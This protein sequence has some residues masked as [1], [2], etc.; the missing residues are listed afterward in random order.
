MTFSGTQGAATLTLRI[1]DSSNV[2][3]QMADVT[4]NIFN[5]ESQLKQ[6]STM[7]ASPG[8]VQE[9]QDGEGYYYQIDLDTSDPV[10][11]PGS[12]VRVEWE[13]TEFA[14]PSSP[15]S[16]RIFSKL[17]TFYPVETMTA[18]KTVLSWLPINSATLRGYII[19]YKYTEDLDYTYLGFSQYPCFIDETSYTPSQRNRILYRVTASL[20]NPDGQLSPDD[21]DIVTAISVWQTDRDLCLVTGVATYATGQPDDHPYPRFLVHHSDAPVNVE[22]QFIYAMSEMIAPPNNF[23]QFALPLIRGTLVTAEIP[24]IGYSRKFIV[25]DQAHVRLVDLDTSLVELYRA[26]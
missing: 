25:P 24:S 20:W 19:E 6:L 17:Y 15:D 26:E 5:S 10:D 14:S 16:T 23:G 13:I 12:L 22:N 7:L 2:G 4:A 3:L 18:L 11:W 9:L 21:G 1:R 8:T